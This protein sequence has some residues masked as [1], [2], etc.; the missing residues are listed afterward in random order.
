MN[1]AH[2]TTLYPEYLTDFES[3]NPQIKAA[4]F[5]EHRTLLYTDAFAWGDYFARYLAIRGKPCLHIIANYPALQHKWASENGFQPD[6]RDPLFSIVR[7]QVQQHATDFLFIE[8]CCAFPTAKVRLLEAAVRLR[9]I[10]CYHGVESNIDHLVPPEALLLTCSPPMAREWH[11]KGY[12]TAILRHAFEPS[13]LLGLPP[14]EKKVDVSFIGSCS[15]LWHPERHDWLLNVMQGVPALEI[16]TDSFR[17]S[18]RAMARAIAASLVHGRGSRVLA[19]FASPL[20]RRAHPAI[21]G[22]KMLA[23]LGDSLVT[24]NAHITQ[25]NPTAGNMR[26]FE[27]TG[28]GACLVTDARDDL[29]EIFEPDVEVVTY[30]TPEESV[31]KVR[32]LLDHPLDAQAIGKRGQDRT[33]RDHTFA[34]RAEQLEQLMIAHT[35]DRQTRS[36]RAAT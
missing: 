25:R 14:S 28:V 12:R 26:L 18:A 32:W 7:A 20:R 34:K 5:A 24:L 27:A 1:I 13:V 19:H 23:Q 31:E 16:W 10:A 11:S 17:K 35:R 9:G 36:H 8:D 29:S 22:R 4:S 15:P 6:S 2:I 21:Y 33:L 30:A 3:R